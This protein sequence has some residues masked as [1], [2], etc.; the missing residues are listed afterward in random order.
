MR[1]GKNEGERA[2]VREGERKRE[3]ES[4]AK[5]FTAVLSLNL[6]LEG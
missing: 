3:K 6:G 4:A 2:R 1:E 5:C